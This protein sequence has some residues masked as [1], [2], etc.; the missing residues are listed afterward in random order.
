MTF[1]ANGEMPPIYEAEPRLT[2]VNVALIGCGPYARSCYVDYF[3]HNDRPEARLAATLDLSSEAPIVSHTLDQFPAQDRPK[4]Y[5]ISE[6]FEPDQLEA[7]LDG[8]VRDNGVNAVILSTPPTQRLQYIT[9]ALKNNIHVLAD[10]PLTIPPNSSVNAEAASQIL[11]DYTLVSDLYRE[12]ISTKPDLVFNL[13]VQRRFHP[14]FQLILE[15]IEE[16][17]EKTGCGITHFQSTHAD[18]QWR[19]PSEV[20]DIGYHGYRDGNGKTSHSGYHF[21]DFASQAVIKSLAAAG[22]Q[23]D[24]ITVYSQPTFPSDLLHTMD[25]DDHHRLFGDEFKNMNKYDRDQYI[26]ATEGYGEV[27][28]VS[29]IS[30]TDAGKRL[31]TGNLNLLHNSLSGRHWLTPNMSDLYRSN[32][33]LKQEMHYITQ[34]PFQSVALSS[35]RGNRPAPDGTGDGSLQLEIFRNDG[36]N[37]NWQPYERFVIDDFIPDLQDPDAHMGWARN[38]CID[39]F[40]DNI[41]QRTLREKRISDLLDHRVSSAVFSSVCRS[42][43]TQSVVHETL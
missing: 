19:M 32:G 40:I 15:K 3:L 26:R 35:L 23:A 16:V 28:C 37:Q 38:A 20:V 1:E 13:M 11:A 25:L 31:S 43:A 4:E 2:D 8:L 42:I 6:D 10:K 14:V 21:V 39:E 24:G 30:F 29:S 17:G 33:R 22:K 7:Y 34:G 27:D 9:W 41:V 18:G 5:Y 36:V 12:S